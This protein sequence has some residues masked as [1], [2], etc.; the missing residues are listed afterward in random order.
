MLR[1]PK[2]GERGILMRGSEGGL[3]YVESLVAGAV[4]VELVLAYDQTLERNMKS[5]Y[6]VDK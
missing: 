5:Y 1:V 4:K 3:G 6:R 2:A